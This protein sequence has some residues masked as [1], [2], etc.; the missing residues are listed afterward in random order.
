MDN[1]TKSNKDTTTKNRRDFIKKA[2][3][4]APVILTMAAT[5]SFASTGSG[6][7]PLV[8]GKRP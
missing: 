1:L 4:A 6:G 8:P 5:P 3:Y 7:H 2:A